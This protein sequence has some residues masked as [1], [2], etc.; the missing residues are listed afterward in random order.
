IEHVKRYVPGLSNL[1]EKLSSVSRAPER[2]SPVSLTTVCGSSS[3]LTH[4][5]CAPASMVKVVG[6]NMKSFTSILFGAAASETAHITAIAAAIS[7]DLIAVSFIPG[8]LGNRCVVEGQ[9]RRMLHDRHAGNPEH[10]GKLVRGHLEWTRAWAF[11]RRRLRIG[12]RASRM[13]HDVAFPFLHDLVNVPVQP[14]DRAEPAQLTHELVGVT[15]SPAPRFV[16]RP[17]RH[18]REDHNGRAR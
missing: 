17:Q 11:A 12:G 8:L 15:G 7:G 18:A 9:C 13:K 6:L 4:E 3:L 16:H 1:N 14:R 5:T 10:F 2:N